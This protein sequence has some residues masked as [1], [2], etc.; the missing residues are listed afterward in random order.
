MDIK[1]GK[2]IDN[3]KVQRVDCLK[4]E[5][6]FN[7]IAHYCDNDTLYTSKGNCIYKGSISNPKPIFSL[8]TKLPISAKEKL[9]S[10]LPITQRMFRSGI[11]HINRYGNRLIIMGFGKIWAVDLVTGNLITDPVAIQGSR[12]LNLCSTPQGLFYGEYHGNPER[13]PMRLFHSKN[14]IDW[15]VFCSFE[16]IRHIHSVFYDPFTSNLWLTTGDDNKESGIWKNTT[17]KP[18]SFVPLLIGSQQ[19]R[20]IQLLFL[21]KYIL[22]GT[23][24]PLEQNFIYAINRNTLE[25]E[26]VIKVDG[27]V[28]YSTQLFDQC[29]ISTAI[30]PSKVN[31]EKMAKIYHIDQN[32]KSQPLLAHKKDIFHKKIF[33]YGQIKFPSGEN[34]Q[35]HLIYST[36][37]VLKDHKTYR[38]TL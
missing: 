15:T 6:I 28:F 26:P 20:A 33:Q 17:D 5:I 11:Y 9:K 31:K 22:Y 1:N 38:V 29:F 36:F 32:L 13:K 4:Q 14:G 34:N 25:R 27:S 23:D 35:Q 3:T 8:F 21:E 18:K 19:E 7:G 37:A 30:E 10:L 12:P 2:L 24:T 16:N